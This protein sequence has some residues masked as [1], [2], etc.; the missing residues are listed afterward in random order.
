[1]KSFVDK[2][3]KKVEEERFTFADNLGFKFSVVK[4]SKVKEIAER[5]VEEEENRKC[6]NCRHELEPVTS[7]VCQYCKRMYSD[8]NFEP[9]EETKNDER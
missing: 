4:I 3:L 9:K 6:E 8:D 5:L 7:E 2:L 1:M